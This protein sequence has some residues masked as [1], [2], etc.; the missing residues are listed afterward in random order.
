MQ[1]FI[2]VINENF[3]VA[4]EAKR[5]KQEEQQ[6]P[7]TSNPW[8][9]MLNPYRWNTLTPVKTESPTST[10]VPEEAES[11]VR[12]DMLDTHQEL[13]QVGANILIFDSTPLLMLLHR[14][15]RR[16][17]AA[18]LI[19]YDGAHWVYSMDSSSQMSKQKIFHSVNCN[20]HLPNREDQRTQ[21]NTN[22]TSTC[23]ELYSFL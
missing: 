3:D 15:A 22:A 6:P 5:K 16:G 1:M 13:N 18:S 8:L 19:I 4:E 14:D 12:H 9:S 11:L 23:K 10:L 2:A 20:G 7:T 17:L 21:L